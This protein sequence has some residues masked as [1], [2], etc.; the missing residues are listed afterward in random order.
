MTIGGGWGWFHL[1]LP[2]YP[3]NLLKIMGL[4]M[5]VLPWTVPWIFVW[6]AQKNCLVIVRWY[7]LVLNFHIPECIFQIFGRFIF[8][9]ICGWFHSRLLKS[10]IYF[11][12]CCSYGIFPLY[13]WFVWQGLYWY[14]NG[15]QW[16]CT[17][18]ILKIYIGTFLLGPCILSL[19][20]LYWRCGSWHLFLLSNGKDG[21]LSSKISWWSTSSRVCPGFFF[22]RR[23]CRLA[24]ISL[25][26]FNVREGGRVD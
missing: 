23:W 1:V 19:Y 21:K 6:T 2:V 15:S 9:H 13:Y 22:S 10:I 18:C 7:Q 3:T 11:F 20:N 24:C 16:R 8:H 4:R 14:H 12:P 17:C 26:E 25:V 5:P